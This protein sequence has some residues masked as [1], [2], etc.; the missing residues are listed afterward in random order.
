MITYNLRDIPEVKQ[1]YSIDDITTTCRLFYEHGFYY[2]PGWDESG[3]DESGWDE[4]S[5]LRSGNFIEIIDVKH[6]LLKDT[7]LNDFE[8]IKHHNFMITEYKG[9]IISHLTK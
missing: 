5:W 7:R 8:Y 9:E 1:V 2:S 6:F 3:W 4:S